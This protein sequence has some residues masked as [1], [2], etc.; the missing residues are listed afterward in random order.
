METGMYGGGKF[1]ALPVPEKIAMIVLGCGCEPP[2]M[3]KRRL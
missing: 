1:V 2:I 3:G